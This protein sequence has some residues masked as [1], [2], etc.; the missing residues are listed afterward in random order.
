MYDYFIGVDP[1]ISN[2]G[3]AV[4]N[5][6]GVLLGY[7]NTSSRSKTKYTDNANIRRL[8]DLADYAVNMI[9]Y[10]LT[11]SEPTTSREDLTRRCLI[12]YEDYSYGSI[13]KSFTIGELGG[14]LKL[15]LLKAGMGLE[16]L[17]PTQLKQFA[18]GTGSASKEAVAA[19]A[20][21]EE[22]TLAVLGQDI[23]TDDLTDAYFLAKWIWYYAAPDLAVKYETSRD[24]L[25]RRLELCQTIR[26]KAK[27]KHQSKETRKRMRR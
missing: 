21:S 5:A 14:V 13:N 6:H 26:K 24:H 17:A 7:C 25:R 19:T 1:S 9:F 11:Q 27:R 18:T 23:A 8:G 20:F 10:Y 15:E 16:M 22:K 2:T 12:G 3:I 4:L